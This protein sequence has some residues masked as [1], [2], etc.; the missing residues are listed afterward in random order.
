MPDSNNLFRREVFKARD[1]SWLGGITVARPM[2]L[3][4][5]VRG[6]VVATSALALFLVFGQYSRHEHVVGILA[7]S[8]G[9][10]AIKPLNSGTVIGVSV[11]DGQ[12]VR[13]D[14]ILL[15]YSSSL[16]GASAHDVPILLAADL[17]GQRERLATDLAAHDGSARLQ[18]ATL[19]AKRDSVSAQLAQIASEVTLAGAQVKSAKLLLAKM[20]P[21]SAEGYVS[22]YKIAELK[23]SM[24]S[25]Q[26]QLSA[27]IR[28]QLEL[29]G[30]LADTNGQLQQAPYESSLATTAIY[31]KIKDIDQAIAQ[32]ESL[33][34]ATLRSPCDCVVS[35]V[36]AKPGQIIEPQQAALFLL[37]THGRIQAELMIP[38]SAIG[39]IAIGSDVL[40]QY[41]AFPYQKYGFQHARIVALSHNT[42]TP[43]EVLALTGVS[44]QNPA[45]QAVADIDRQSIA[46]KKGTYDLTPG[47]LVSADI[48]VERRTLLSWIWAPNIVADHG[49]R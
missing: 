14:Q 47:L 31:D 27:L 20:L 46:T 49:G 4:W 15:S 1:D 2:S 18:M 43:A 29:E 22:S 21:L 37:P 42:L 36:L 33:R 48:V 45:Y 28:Q 10:I 24:M 30:Q 19:K 26:A 5:L 41:S 39:G 40:L 34:A 6:V 44:V 7:P 13:K 3:V 9:L 8:A 38:E 11:Q 25:Y 17:Y 32:Y 12:M 16:V 35:T 23:A